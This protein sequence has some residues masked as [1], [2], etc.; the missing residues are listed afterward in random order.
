[1]KLFGLLPDKESLVSLD[2]GATSIKMLELDL[3]EEKP[4][5]VNIGIAP[6]SAD[7]FNG[8]LIIKSEKIAEQI[9]TLLEANAIGDKR[10]ATALPGPSVFTKRIKMP[11]MKPAELASSV[12]FEAGNFI[13]QNIDAIKIDFHVIG[14]AGKSQLDVLVVAVKDE[15]LDS[16]LN[17]LALSGLETAV[18]DVDYFALQ[19]V[20]ELGYPEYFNQT[21][22]LINIGARYSSINIC[23]AGESLFTGDISVGGKLFSDAIAEGMGMQPAEAE[24]LKKNP[25]AGNPNLDLYQD[26]IDR[27]VEYAASEFNRQLS[28]FWNASGAEEGIDRVMLC[29]GGALIPG[30]VEELS[31]KT[32]LECA[33][34]DPL[35]GVDC[36]E[37]FDQ[38]YLKQIAP[39]MGIA[40]GLGLRQ[41]GDK[42]IPDYD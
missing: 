15:I 11:K 41:P 18:A 17:C 1:M 35:K 5:L 29:G 24:Q 42:E 2:I 36:E 12:Y 26:I 9:S 14:E 7:V 33:Q 25:K 20:F 3:K 8:N 13:P 23:R 27:N 34:L 39:L 28:F 30:L 10:A 32:G 16:Y 22:A 6:L 19:N 38:A 21:V 4:R 40:V 37:G 31:E